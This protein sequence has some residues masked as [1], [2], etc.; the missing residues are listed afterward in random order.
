MQ[1]RSYRNRNRGVVKE[2][3]FRFEFEGE[4]Y[5]VTGKLWM[6]RYIMFP[7]VRF[8]TVGAF[9]KNN[10][11]EVDLSTHPP[12]SSDAALEATVVNPAPIY[13]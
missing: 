9:L 12:Y 5:Q 4:E 7:D 10:K 8:A 13:A 1:S 11:L 3:T 6:D 2:G